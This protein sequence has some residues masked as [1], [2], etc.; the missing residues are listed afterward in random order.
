[1]DC[2]YIPTRRCTSC[3][4]SLAERPDFAACTAMR[5]RLQADVTFDLY[6]QNY[7]LTQLP[8]AADRGSLQRV[9]HVIVSLGGIPTVN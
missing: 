6:T 7:F 2:I 1:M 8:P 4:C 5:S 9:A 3:T